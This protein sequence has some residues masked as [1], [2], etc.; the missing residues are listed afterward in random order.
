MRY[1]GSTLGVALAI[2]LLDRPSATPL[3][4][5]HHVWW[6]LVGV[7]ITVSIIAT[8]LAR[9]PATAGAPAVALALD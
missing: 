7:G 3:D 8:R 4:N 6:L 5:F 9:R 2:A 1:V